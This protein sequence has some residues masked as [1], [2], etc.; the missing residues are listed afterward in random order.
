MNS[1]AECFCFHED[2]PA[3]NDD[4]D[5]NDGGGPC[6]INSDQNFSS[7]GECDDQRGAI[8]TVTAT[9]EDAAERIQ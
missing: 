9:E 5:G 6:A 2:T 8:K 3:H 1:F 7:N 4:D